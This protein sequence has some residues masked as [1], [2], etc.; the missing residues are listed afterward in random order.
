MEEYKPNSY[1]YKEAQKRKK[2]TTEKKLEKVIDGKAVVKK[3]SSGE[4]FLS[5]F[6]S[7]DI[8]NVKT[9][10]ISD[11][12]VPSLKK[13]I[14]EVVQMLLYGEVRH[15]SSSRKSQRV[16]YNRYYEE[17]DRD[18]RRRNRRD[19]YDYDHIILESRGEAQHVINTLRDIID[20]YGMASVGDLYEIVGLDSENYQD[21]KYGWTSLNTAKVEPTRDGY[22]LRF[23]R[24]VALD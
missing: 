23:P 10:I 22:E 9:Y 2:N 20:E 6:L 24:V 21:H 5:Q 18:D 4:K 15:D 12:L 14:D 3:K 13:A 16:S 19:S 7:D 11:V 17:R 8:T 1:A